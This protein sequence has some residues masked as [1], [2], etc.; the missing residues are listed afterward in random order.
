MLMMQAARAGF[1][2]R[3]FVSALVCCLAAGASPAVQLEAED[4]VL[5][6]TWVSTAIPGY[7]GSGYV[8]GFVSGTNESVAITVT[9]P[10]AGSYRLTLRY[11]SLFDVKLTRL[12]VNGADAGE[13]VLA[14]SA[15]FRD[16]EGPTVSLAAGANTVTIYSDW[17][18]Y[19]IDALLVEPVAQ[20][21]DLFEAEAGALSDTKPAPTPAA[22]TWRASRRR[23]RP[24]RSRSTWLSPGTTM[25][26][27]ATPR[28]RMPSIRRSS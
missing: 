23:M 17:G 28:R 19:E 2:S 15:S 24:W 7:S 27:C 4:G 13:V 3:L 5:T 10:A 18:Y 26:G 22:A 11:A 12:Y 21:P 6:N 25:S 20:P 1:W 8:T 14:Q 9:V 16:A